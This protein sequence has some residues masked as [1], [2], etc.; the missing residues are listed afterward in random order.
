MSI[1]SIGTLS[2]GI[3]SC[4]PA[5]VGTTYNIWKGL[6]VDI[7]GTYTI[8]TVDDTTG[9]AG[10]AIYLAAGIVHP[11]PGTKIVSAAA[12]STNITIGY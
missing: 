7:T 2:T 5:T 1:Q 10:T 4:V 9:G 8:V 3:R 6:I 11:I 12:G